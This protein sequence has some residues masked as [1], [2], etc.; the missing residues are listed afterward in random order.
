MF[1]VYIAQVGTAELEAIRACTSTLFSADSV[2]LNC[3]SIVSQYVSQT[4][5]QIW[6]QKIGTASAE[7]LILINIARYIAGPIIGFW[8][9]YVF[10][11]FRR[12]GMADG[13]IE[14]L[15]VI[16]I[17]LMLFG[18]NGLPVRQLTLAGRALMNYQNA[19]V[20]EI[21]NEAE[22]YETHYAEI[23]DYAVLEQQLTD[24][25]S[26]CIGTL[27]NEDLLE[28]LQNAEV[29]A[30]AAIDTYRDEHQNTP[31]TERLVS[32]ATATIQNAISSAAPVLGL[33]GVFSNSVGK[34]F[35][36]G[37]LATMNGVIQNLVELTWLLTAIIAPIPIAISIY[38]GARGFF[39]GWIVA[40]LSL[41][42]FKI[43]LNIA[44]AV[45]VSMIYNR[46]PGDILSD[47]MLLSLGVVV[48]ALGMTAGGGLALFNGISSAVTATTLGML[49]LSTRG[50]GSFK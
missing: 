9:I 12:N 37:I 16:L 35:I 41:G 1:D 3:G 34:V 36:Q 27:R 32:F 28:C 18:S 4:W 13:F 24:I 2:A 47:L 25:R 8:G 23:A 14:L 19:R 21:L 38:P 6:E 11:A 45:I 17:V 22:Q 48:L 44:T 39:V 42:L 26:Q 33:A 46:G 15:P 10:R 29:Q 31:W 5:D 40:F 43:N 49:N 30:L 7:Y 50:I 20:L